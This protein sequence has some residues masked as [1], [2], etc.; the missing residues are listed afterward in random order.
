MAKSSETAKQIQKTNIGFRNDYLFSG[1][2][3]PIHEV[4]KHEIYELDNDD[5]L[6]FLK[7]DDINDVLDYIHKTFTTKAPLYGYWFTSKHGVES[8]YAGDTEPITKF[9]LPEK[10][11]ILS[12][13]GTDGIL[14]VSNTPKSKLKQELLE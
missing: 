2:D 3:Y 5:I 14:I 10:Y 13:L 7:V 8:S 4:L 6:E 11:L 1:E 9:Y 12:D